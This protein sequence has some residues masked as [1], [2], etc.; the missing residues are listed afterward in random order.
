MPTDPITAA[1]DAVQT[2]ITEYWRSRAASYDDHRHTP[3]RREPDHQVWTDVWAGVLPAAP[4]DVLDVGTGT[5]Y[6]AGIIAELGHRVTGIDL[7]PEML[8]V[9]A[10]GHRDLS[11]PPTLLPGDAVDPP[12][13]PGTFDVICARYVL[14]TL[15]LPDVALARWR[16]LLRP[17]G[18]IAVV[19]STWFPRGIEDGTSVTPGSR[20][21]SFRR[22]YDT[23]VRQ[24][25]P[26]AEATAISQTAERVAAA[27]FESVTTTPLQALYDLDARV[28]VSEGHEVQMQYLITATRP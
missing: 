25:L 7:A 20:E 21:D 26:L 9:A 14:W 1:D 19:D 12:F 22:L 4:A 15:R 2:N 16:T 10:A 27:G 24:A 28:G 17:G 11:N 13:G 18:T 6:V 5:G 23:A 8:Q 3:A